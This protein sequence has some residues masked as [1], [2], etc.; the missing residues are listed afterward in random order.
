MSI[1]LRI[2]KMK[3]SDY[4]DKIATENRH[5]KFKKLPLIVVTTKE[6]EDKFGGHFQYVPVLGRIG[7]GSKIHKITVS[8][9]NTPEGY[10]VWGAYSDCG[11]QK[12]GHGG[13]SRIHIFKSNDLSKVTC[14]KCLGIRVKGGKKPEPKTR[15]APIDPL[16][17]PRIFK[18]NFKKDII[19]T[20]WRPEIIGQADQE[21]ARGMTPEEAMKKIIRQ[22]MNYGYYLKVYDFELISIRAW[23]QNLLWSKPKNA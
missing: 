4:L 23:N 18:F 16:S 5:R 8:M 19:A 20:A 13:E 3:F 14:D 2:G 10:I 9:L 12:W 22:E 15:R 21:S 11:S 6:L 7:M 1:G 17:R